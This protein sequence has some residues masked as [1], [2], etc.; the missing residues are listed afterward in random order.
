MGYSS[1]AEDATEGLSVRGP[2]AEAVGVEYYISPIMVEPKVTHEDL[3]G[4]DM[5][6]ALL[7]VFFGS[8]LIH[9]A[10]VCTV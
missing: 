7:R 5:D 9:P 10:G 2:S 1:S 4:V 6:L 8:Y 3:K